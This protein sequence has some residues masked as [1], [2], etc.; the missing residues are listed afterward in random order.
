MKIRS[1]LPQVGVWLLAYFAVAISGQDI[2]TEKWTRISFD[3]NELS[4]AVP[5]YYLVDAEKRS[6]GKWLHVMAF[7]NGVSIDITFEKD[8]TG[9]IDRIS[10]TKGEV[11]SAFKIDKIQGR[12]IT[13]SPNE[14]K[15]AQQIYLSSGDRFYTVTTEAPTLS[16]DVLIRFLYSLLIDDKPVFKRSATIDVP[17]NSI[18]ASALTTSVEVTAAFPRKPDKSSGT[19]AYKKASEYVPPSEG[20]STVVPAMVVDRPYPHP[21]GTPSRDTMSADVV[22]N[23][24]AN[25]QI[26]DVTVYSD[27]GRDFASACADA[28]RKIKF[29]PAHN[30][31][32]AV[33]YA[34]VEHYSVM[35]R[36]IR[37]SGPVIV[38]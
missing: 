2:R 20:S 22:V 19:T 11:A 38:Q 33:D 37:I 9:R 4:V 13:S 25:G 17:E 26:G 15:F 34:R 1:R 21:S 35:V 18:A 23:Y 12:V 7:E 16:N 3:K 27:A 29:I 6:N 31:D 28:A 32:K 8:D 36:A 24:L 30:G 10:P 14:H 5:N